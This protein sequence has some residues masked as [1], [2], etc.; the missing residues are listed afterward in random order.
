MRAI[1]A[2]LFLVLLSVIPHFGYAQQVPALD[3]EVSVRAQQLTISEVLSDIAQKTGIKFSYSPAQIGADRKVSLQATRKPLRVVLKM[4]LGETVQFKA[5]GNFIILTPKPASEQQD[6]PKE[7]T[8]SGYV[9]DEEGNTLA[10]ASILSRKEQTA[11]VTNKY[12]Y[13]KLQVPANKLP[14]DIKVEKARYRDTAVRVSARQTQIEVIL[15][16]VKATTHKDTA[17]H[18]IVIKEDS[19]T[20]KIVQTDN[21]PDSNQTLPPAKSWIDRVLLSD[22]TRANIRNVTD[23]LFSNVQFSIIPQLSTNKLLVGNTV[24]NASL[25]LLVG[26]SKG[27]N[28]LGVAGVANIVRGNAS[29]VLAAGVANIVQDTMQGAQ[30]AG[31][32]NVN[33]EKVTGAQVAGVVNITDGDME[34]VQTA[35]VGNVQTGHL[36]GVQT[37]GVFNINAQQ[38]EGVQVAGVVNVNQ[39]KM[40]GTEVAGV[41]NINMDSVTGAQVAGVANVSIAPVQGTQVAGVANYGRGGVCYAQVSGVVNVFHGDIKGSQVS[42]VVN[43]AKG[44]VQGTQVSS[45]L[46]VAKHVQGTQVGLINISETCEGVPVGLISISKKGYHKLELFGDEAMYTQLAFR[47]G[48]TGFHNI[49]ISGVDL[50]SRISGLWN[51]G[52]GIGSYHRMAENWLVGGEI[53]SQLY[54]T[55]DM[56]KNAVQLNSLHIGFEHRFGKSFSLGF[57]PSF[58]VMYNYHNNTD[59]QR[60][61]SPWSMYNETFSDG[62]SLRVWA[63]GKLSLKFF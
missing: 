1:T 55:G 40:W 3:R 28:Y 47:T 21:A 46:N 27:L 34:G 30:L 12:G 52:Y 60:I 20:A 51:F 29:Y 11:A 22:E 62:S 41:V 16:G 48:V 53:T 56:D 36:H 50:T 9:Y 8:I 35:G 19:L 63:G 57:G 4:L 33:G 39:G 24:N 43:I 10:Y 7:V 44:H 5:K 59:I 17:Y 31:V 23:T 32:V 15:T 13:F 2:C 54:L 6:I 37:G 25:S 61:I 26:Y 49:F 14:L 58:R 42:G 38:T 45:V 18:A